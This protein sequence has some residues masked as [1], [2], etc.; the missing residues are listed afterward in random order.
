MTT[1]SQHSPYPS[2]S[3]KPQLVKEPESPEHPVLLISAESSFSSQLLSGLIA[4]DLSC[5][6]RRLTPQTAIAQSV[7]LALIDCHGLGVK[8][9]ALWLQENIHQLQYAA[10]IHVPHNK[11][12]ERL[13]EWPKVNGLFYDDAREAQ[14]LQGVRRVLV[15]ELWLP[16]RLLT[17]HLENCR[18]TH[19]LQA[20][21]QLTRR[22]TEI[23]RLMKSGVTNAEI[24]E[25]LG[26]S[27]HTVKSHLYNAYRK[28]G[29]NNRMDAGN[30]ARANVD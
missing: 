6:C 3:S 22:E 29:A 10:L 9:I 27:A 18:A 12:Y 21:T 1:L 4:K 17:N 28:I 15:G 2:T 5:S 13:I 30:W 20:H 19:P 23:L 24:G 11:N 26:L 7:E 14:L 25:K 8:E 16:R